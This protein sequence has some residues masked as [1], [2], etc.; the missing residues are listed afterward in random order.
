MPESRIKKT[1][2]NSTVG[3]ISYLLNA[4]LS[5]IGR[6]VF[7]RTLGVEYLG[8]GGLF[9]NILVMLSLSDLGIYTVMTYSL[10]KPI[11]ENDTEKIAVYIHYFQKLYNI[12]AFVVLGIGLAL[13]PILP[14]IVNGSDLAY[15]DLIKYYVI[16]LANSVV[17]YFAIS[18][19]TL[20]RADQ[21][22]Y[23]VR[24]ITT[25]TNAMM[26]VTQIILLVVFRNYVAFLV[27][28]VCFTFGNNLVLSI[29]ATKKY[30]YLKNKTK[31]GPEKDVNSKI[32][33]NLKASFL[34]KVGSLVLNSTDNIL[35]SIIVSTVMVGYYTNYVTVFS[36]VNAFIMII[37]EAVLA[38]VGNYIATESDEKKYRLFRTLM[39]IMYMIAA[40]CVSCYIAGMN[41]FIRIWLGDEFVIGG[42]FIFALS[43]NRFVFC[44]IHP[45]W[46]M[47]ESSGVF[48]ETQFVMI[49]AAVIN[50]ILSV[51]LGNCW[52]IT[53]IILATAI[54]YLLTVYWFEPIQLSRKIFHVPLRDYW[55]Y[56]LKLLGSCAF[57]IIF[58]SFVYRFETNN[59]VF[60]VLKFLGCGLVAFGTFYVM[61]KNSE[62]FNGLYSMVR[63][64]IFKGSDK[65][66]ENT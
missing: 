62:E 56:V 12:I 11:A 60:L 39:L 63:R 20:F 49:G 25:V 10:Y 65:Q 61:F 27:C 24:I 21:N 13:I 28:Q 55:R 47:R 29:M 42:A 5:F 40:F 45:L 9:S 48:S 37:I 15:N 51:I 26:H 66:I 22:V 17:S 50:L 19:S 44:S 35:I 1:F 58:A 46:M 57:P 52:G 33:Q 59:I 64:T 54:S 6:I 36:L 31:N 43:I 38:S 7:I 8:I 16:L 53:G 23:I 32:I 2:R 14:Q 41:D 30:P 34:Y 3:I 18:K 4:G